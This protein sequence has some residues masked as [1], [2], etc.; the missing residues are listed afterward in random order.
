MI[1]MGEKTQKERKRRGWG[2]KTRRVEERMQMHLDSFHF[3]MS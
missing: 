2:T 3:I 1:Y